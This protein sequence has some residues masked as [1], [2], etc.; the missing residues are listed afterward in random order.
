[1]APSAALKKRRSK[2]LSL[3]EVSGFA[4][5]MVFLVAL[6]LV[7][8]SDYHDLPQSY[9]AKPLPGAN[10]EGLNAMRD[11]M[12]YLDYQRVSMNDL[13]AFLREG[14]KKWLRAEGLS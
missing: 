13:P 3:I 7:R 10:R 5:T 12:L 2:P 11:G 1:M 9:H 6:F 8:V 14:V 4:S